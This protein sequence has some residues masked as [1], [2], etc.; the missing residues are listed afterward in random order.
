M[1]SHKK[2]GPDRFSRFDVYWIK[3]NKKKHHIRQTE[4]TTLY[5]DSYF[6][7]EDA[8]PVDQEDLDSEFEVN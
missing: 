5:I 3:T 6:S 4:I 8:V 1:R 2:F 7:L